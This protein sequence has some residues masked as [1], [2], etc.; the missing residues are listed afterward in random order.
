MGNQNATDEQYSIIGRDEAYED[1][2]I[3]EELPTCPICGP[4][5]ES[6]DV[7]GF[8]GRGNPGKV[9]NTLVQT[10][11]EVWDILSAGPLQRFT[12]NGKLVHNCLVLDHAGT[13]GRA[14]AVYRYSPL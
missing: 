1:N 7:S 12:V 9:G 8:D 11:R 10:E 13:A 3:S 2:S 5:S 4:D 6:F 14:G